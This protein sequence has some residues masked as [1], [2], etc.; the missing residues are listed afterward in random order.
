MFSVILYITFFHD[1]LLNNF[2]GNINLD[3]NISCVKHISINKC[4][5]KP[6]YY[7]N[8]LKHDAKCKQEYIL[9]YLYKEIVYNFIN[10]SNAEK[11]ISLW[12]RF[13]SIF[14]GLPKIF[15]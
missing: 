15:R 1:L 12:C 10:S 13:I 6:K 5:K 11:I 3:Y 7:I 8:K 9:Y 2:H 14:E 4:K